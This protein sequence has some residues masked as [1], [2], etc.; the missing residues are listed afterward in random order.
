[1]RPLVVFTGQGIPRADGLNLTRRMKGTPRLAALTADV[2]RKDRQNLDALLEACAAAGDDALTEVLQDLRVICLK[3]RRA[4]LRKSTHRGVFEVLSAVAEQ[5]LVAHLTTNLDGLTTTF[6]VRDF[7]ACWPPFRGPCHVDALRREMQQVLDRGAG[8]LHV[9]LHGEAGLMLAEPA[10]DVLQ[11][12]YGAPP[13]LPG[14]AVSWLPSLR[15]GATAGMAGI[16]QRLVTAGLGYALFSALVSTSPREADGLVVARAAPADLVVIGYGAEESR[17]RDA[18]PFERAVTGLVAAG[19]RD[20]AAQW[21]ALVYRPEE[22]PLSAQ[23]YAARTFK[24]VPYGD[25]ELPQVLRQAI[26]RSLPGVRSTPDDASAST[27]R[28]LR[29]P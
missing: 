20:P 2:R 4:T 26:T 17:T 9:P 19:H 10:G 5:R 1:M 29:R 7:A 27:Q 22:N 25:G 11:T 23:W 24:V 14:D 8:L 16:E 18:Y 3:E 21:T 12:F 28:E 6:A 15:R 13:S